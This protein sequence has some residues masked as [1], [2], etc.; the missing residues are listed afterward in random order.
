L[1]AAEAVEAMAAKA[2]AIMAKDFMVI[3]GRLVG[4]LDLTRTEQIA[5]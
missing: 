1:L 4:V 3:V 5:E 2:A